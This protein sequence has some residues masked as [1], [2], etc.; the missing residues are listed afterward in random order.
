MWV[1]GGCVIGVDG[2]RRGLEL[3]LVDG[4]V[5]VMVVVA[6]VGGYSWVVSVPWAVVPATCYLVSDAC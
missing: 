4:R 3:V 1:G 5:M 2:A 6:V